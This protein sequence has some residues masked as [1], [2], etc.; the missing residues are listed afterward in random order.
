MAE[1]ARWFVERPLKIILILLVS[2]VINR[3]VRRGIDRMVSRL[4]ETREKEQEVAEV[5]SNKM[6]AVMGNRARRKLQRLAEQGDRSRQRAL[7]LGAVL[8]GISTGVIYLLGMMIALGELGIDLGPLIA[9]A[10]IIGLAVGFG[11]Q[12]L[13]A[14]FIAG[15]FVII[16]DQYGVGDWIDV[17]PASGTVER[18]TLRT[19]VLRDSHGTVWVIPN[20]EIHRVGNS[21]QLWAKTVLDL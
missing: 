16:E 11:A 21:S 9:G 1:T 15:I 10:G 12:D 5:E 20:G 7:T 2:M 14:N 19:T 18:V 3:V 13:V 4:I 17:G 8:R 6:L